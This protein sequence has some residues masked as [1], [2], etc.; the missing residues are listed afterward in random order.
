MCALKRG[1]VTICLTLAELFYASFDDGGGWRQTLANEL[2]S[3]GFEINWNQ[4]MRP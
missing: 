1:D 2:Q 4:V 3:A